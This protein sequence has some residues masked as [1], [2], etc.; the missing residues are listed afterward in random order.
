MR[1]GAAFNAHRRAAPDFPNEKDSGPDPGALGTGAWDR[2]RCSLLG[3][4]S[5]RILLLGP[6]QQYDLISNAAPQS[7]AM[8]ARV[9][10][11]ALPIDARIRGLLTE[12]GWRWE[13][14][15]ISFLPTDEVT[16][17]MRSEPT[18]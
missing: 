8:M 11:R 13:R 18:F 17:S 5:A 4:E 6:F 15:P 14:P 7:I 16:Q 12:L 1:S 10:W 3:I 9:M 2:G